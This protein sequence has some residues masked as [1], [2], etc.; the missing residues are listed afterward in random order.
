[1][2]IEALKASASPESIL[3]F[4]GYLVAAVIL[5]VVF[6]TLYHLVT[7]HKELRLIREGNMSA[8]IAFSGTVIAL[9]FTVSTSIRISEY[10]VDFL[11][12]GAI[13]FA[14][15]VFAYVLTHLL[16]RNL[17]QRIVNNEISAA[18][19]LSGVSISLALINAACMTPA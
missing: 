1:M 4:G 18:F 7:P 15:Q 8:A 13:S 17:S 6:C 19:F 16:I 12:W 9:A 2:I 11:V 10:I 5:M 3:S 14:V